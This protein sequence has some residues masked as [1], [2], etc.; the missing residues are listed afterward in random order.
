MS[1]KRTSLII[2]KRF[3]FHHILHALL[4]T[5]IAINVVVIAMFTLMVGKI[6]VEANLTLGISIAVIEVVALMGIL[7]IARRSSN[8]IAGPVYR[9]CRI[10]ESVGNGDLTAQV[11]LRQ[12]DNFREQ[13]DNINL[14][15]G[16]LH[17]RIENIQM[18]SQQLRE[19]PDAELA[20]RLHNELAE[21]RTR[22]NTP[23]SV[24]P[25]TKDAETNAGHGR[26]SAAEGFT[27]IELMLIILV[28]SILALIAIPLYQNY[29]IR[30][31]ISE[32]FLIADPVKRALMEYYLE[33]G[34]FPTDNDEAAVGPPTDYKATYVDQ[35]HVE[36]SGVIRVIYDI[37]A[38][39]PKT[40]LLLHPRLESEGAL[41]WDC[42]D[43]TEAFAVP[44]RFRPAVCRK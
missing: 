7:W 3:Q 22:S 15:L 14:A 36:P 10:M 26:H 41:S 19:K 13:G 11:Q 9:I 34:S 43:D 32:G 4:L 8:R 17:D 6:D 20:E 23:E 27:L 1:N 39:G 5:F 37:T 12:H 21:F 29:S 30:A 35:I 42:N 16:R 24:S 2:D 28:I 25:N 33:K 38:L 18:L 40:D 44:L 31:Q